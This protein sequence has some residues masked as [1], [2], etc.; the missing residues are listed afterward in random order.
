MTMLDDMAADPTHY[1]HGTTKGFQLG[2]RCWR[3]SPMADA[4]IA[5]R[6]KPRRRLWTPREDAALMALVDKGRTVREIATALGRSVGA[7]KTRLNDKGLSARR[8]NGWTK[9]EDDELLRLRAEGLS[10]VAAAERIGR[11]KD[12]VYARLHKLSDGGVEVPKP[13]PKRK[14]D[15]HGTV[16]CYQAGCRCTECKAAAAAYWQRRKGRRTRKRESA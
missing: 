16:S 12:A 10:C 14:K 5:D 1:M 9:A 7:I 8:A 13:R 6:P 3:C 2:C 11:T 15:V 4:V